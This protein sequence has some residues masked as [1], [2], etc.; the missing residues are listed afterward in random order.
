M[1]VGDVLAMVIVAAMILWV[2]LK[3]AWYGDIILSFILVIA[4][5]LVIAMVWLAF[6]GLK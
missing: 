4:V 1:S 3:L 5:I 2:I 6:E